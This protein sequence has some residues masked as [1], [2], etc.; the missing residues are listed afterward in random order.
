MPG[1]DPANI[2]QT[3]DKEKYTNILN[4]RRLLWVVPGGYDQSLYNEDS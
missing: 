3:G 1:E 4:K 2:S